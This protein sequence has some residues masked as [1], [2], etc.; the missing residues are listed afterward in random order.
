[1]TGGVENLAKVNTDADCAIGK[2]IRGRRT[3]LGL[4]LKEVALK[5]GISIGLLSQIERGL[6]SLTMRSLHAIS[7][8]LQ[9]SP[10]A[11]FGPPQVSDEKARIVVRKSERRHVEFET[12]VS[13]DLMTPQ[14]AKGIEMLFVTIEPHGTSGDEFYTHPGEEAGFVVSGS[15]RLYVDQEIFNLEK[16]DA[17]RFK[18][19]IP[20]RFENRGAETSEVVWFLTSPYYV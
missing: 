17:F 9:V 4:S 16:G 8:A 5:S 1:M 11:F 7:D 2:Q 19:T 14:T 3:T 15:V 10:A 20:H 18:S 13:K 12:G 6:S